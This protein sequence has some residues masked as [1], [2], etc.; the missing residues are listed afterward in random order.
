TEELASRHGAVVADIQRDAAWINDGHPMR[1]D[2][3][4]MLCLVTSRPLLET[5]V[6]SR[7]AA[8]PGI[9]LQPDTEAVGL[10]ATGPNSAPARRRA[11]R[12]TGLRIRAN[13]EERVLAADLVVDATGRSNRGPTWLRE[14]GYE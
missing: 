4:D 9:T 13:S 8:L 3:A 14:L 2:F 5:Y 10:V 1:R 12:V 6:R 7:V 11:G